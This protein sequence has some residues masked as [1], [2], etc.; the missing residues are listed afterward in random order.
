[1]HS[2]LL[3]IGFAIALAAP[4]F[5]ETPKFTLT[6]KDHVFAPAEL[7]VPSGEKIELR[8][9]NQDQTAEEFES[10]DLHREKV[11]PGGGAVTIFVGPLKPGAY[12][13]IGEFHPKTAFG[14]IIAR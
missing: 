6:I 13:Y 3:S 11:I 2:W 9:V 8:I 5:A 4:S 7:V 12:K 10:L 14:N 1:M